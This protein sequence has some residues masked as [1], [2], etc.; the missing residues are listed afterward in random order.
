MNG[1]GAERVVATLANRYVAQDDD[2]TIL[3]VAG[4]TSVYPLDS[5]I[6]LLTI[7]RPSKGNPL[8]QIKRL[9][10]MRKYFKDNRDSHF[11]VFSTQINIFAIVA[12]MGLRLSLIVSERNDP[13]QYKYTF[14]R[15]KLYE[16]G[17]KK[18]THFVFQTEDAQNCF[19]EKVQRRS[20]VIPNPLRID[21][22]DPYEGIREKK[23]AAVGRLELQKNQKLLL[24]AY[25][26]FQKNYPEYELYIYGA[27]RLEKELKKYTGYLGIA[28][29]VHFEGFQKDILETIKAYSM[30][31]LSSDYE[32]ISNSLMEAMAL[33]LPCISTDCPI[34]GSRLCIENEVN[35]LLIPVRD[36]EK[37]QEAME[38]LVKDTGLAEKLGENAVKI[39]ET[40]AEKKIADT[41]HAYI[42]ICGGD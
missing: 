34:G 12:A 25:A 37:L 40:F 20:M 32:G 6:K 16:L 17:A 8:I 33:G 28:N 19:A 23:I 4:D 38:R 18:D 1:G 9:L 29:K 2:V 22:P 42:G 11:V 41:W 30:Y 24:K 26:N 5:R 36:V 14:L 10:A 21:M 27:G 31:I 39:R 7:G 13:D 3:M 15:N 35:G